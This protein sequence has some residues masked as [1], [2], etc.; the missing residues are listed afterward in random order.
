MCAIENLGLFDLHGLH[1]GRC[2]GGCQGDTN[3]MPAAYDRVSVLVK[4]NRT[5]C[6]PAIT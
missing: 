1:I 3:E 5:P 2:G 4:L 6:V